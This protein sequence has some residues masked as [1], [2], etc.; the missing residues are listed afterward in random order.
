MY[1]YASTPAAGRTIQVFRAGASF[2]G[3]SVTWSNQPTTT[4]TAVTSPSLSAS[5]Y[6]QWDVTSLV[7]SQYSGINNGFVVRDA[8][9]SAGTAAEQTY[10]SDNAGS[11]FPVLVVTFG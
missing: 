8:S 9:E 1:M 7:A 10:I 3:S 2:N 4:G 11:G 6:Q 5:G